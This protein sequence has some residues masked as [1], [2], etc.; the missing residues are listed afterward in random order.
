MNKNYEISL[1]YIQLDLSKAWPR[2]MDQAIDQAN[3]LFNKKSPFRKRQIDETKLEYAQKFI[4]HISEWIDS[5]D[6][7]I[8]HSPVINQL[9]KILSVNI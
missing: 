4:N 9:S 6:S 7:G 2:H 1:A 8:D 3:K 5:Q